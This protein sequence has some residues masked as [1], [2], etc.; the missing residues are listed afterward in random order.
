VCKKAKL[1]RF[2]MQFGEGSWEPRTPSVMVLCPK[3]GKRLD[4]CQPGEVCGCAC[5]ITV[6]FSNA[7]D[8][9]H[10]EVHGCGSSIIRVLQQIT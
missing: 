4:M 5:K 3:Y 6:A 7:A 1:F 2:Q 10:Y 9:Q 8:Q